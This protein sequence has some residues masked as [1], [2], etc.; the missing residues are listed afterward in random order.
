ML[1]RYGQVELQDVYTTYRE[2]EV[3]AEE[4]AAVER[5]GSK[6]CSSEGGDTRVVDSVGCAD[7]PIAVV[8]LER[9]SRNSWPMPRSQVLQRSG[10][11]YGGGAKTRRRNIERPSWDRDA[12]GSCA[13]ARFCG[14][15]S[16]RRALH[17][18]PFYASNNIMAGIFEQPR[19]AGTLCTS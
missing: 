2:A 18:P 17:I 9:S 14:R 5:K 13:L 3:S 11:V 19:N 12:G 4:A 8:G 6:E 10:C 1:W 7:S 16:A 15:S